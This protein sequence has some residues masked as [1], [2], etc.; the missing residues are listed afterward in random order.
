MNI[1][2]FSCLYISVQDILVYSRNINMSILISC[3]FEKIG[4][5]VFPLGIL[6]YTGKT[7][8]SEGTE[9]QCLFS[10]SSY[11]SPETS[12]TIWISLVSNDWYPVIFLCK[13]LVVRGFAGNCVSLSAWVFVTIFRSEKFSFWKKGKEQ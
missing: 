2:S 1:S 8:V 12:N 7:R 10:Y 9:Q 3:D 4:Q 11:F 13:F 5:F 6:E